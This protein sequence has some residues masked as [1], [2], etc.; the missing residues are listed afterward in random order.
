MVPPVAATF[1]RSTPAS[2][3]SSMDQAFPSGSSC[4]PSTTIVVPVT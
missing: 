2:W 1:L 3:T 4:P